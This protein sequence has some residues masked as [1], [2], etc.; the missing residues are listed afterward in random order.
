MMN[1]LLKKQIFL[2][3]KGKS[4]YKNIYSLAQKVLWHILKHKCGPMVWIRY[5]YITL[6]PKRLKTLDFHNIIIILRMT[7]I[8]T[9]FI[10]LIDTKSLRKFTVISLRTPKWFIPIS[11]SLIMLIFTSNQIHVQYVSI[12]YTPNQLTLGSEINLTHFWAKFTT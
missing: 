4:D 5:V 1:E 7:F 11:K 6:V 8:F 12:F 10:V 2:L 3:L 9:K